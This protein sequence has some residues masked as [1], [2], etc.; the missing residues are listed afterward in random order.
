M[1]EPKTKNKSLTFWLVCISVILVLTGIIIQASLNSKNKEAQDLKVLSNEWIKGNLDASVTI[2][3]YSDF[4]CPACAFYFSMTQQLIEEIG[5]EARLVYRHFPLDSIHQNAKMAARAAEAA[6]S[7]GKFWEMHDLLFERQDQ[8]SNL[9]DPKETFIGYAQELALDQDQF[10]AALDSADIK[11]AVDE[12]Q[13]S[14]FGF[15]LR[16]TPTFFVNGVQ[17][18]NPQSYDEFKKIILDSR[19]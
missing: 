17:I 8:W 10:S 14:G 12:D 3:E 9:S 2:V 5:N 19:P 15:G 18:D 11:N 7:M 1:L 6:G 4:Q 13:S 16:G